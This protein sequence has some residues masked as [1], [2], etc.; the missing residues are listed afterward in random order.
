VTAA[1]PDTA[2]EL[3]SID[4]SVSRFTVR[5]FASG[6]LSAMGHSP[7]IAIRDFSGEARFNRDRPEASSLR[8]EIHASSLEVTDDIKSSD[9]REIESTMH[10]TV[11]ET[12]RYPGIVFETSGV[13]AELVAPGRYRMA[14]NGAL[15]LHGVT[16]ALRLVA[17]VI[18]VGDSLRAFGEFAVGQSSFGIAPVSVA[19]GTL[20]LKDELKCDFDIVAR[21]Q[22]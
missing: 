18:L 6:M 22:D 14:L 10:Q 19:G 12:A 1:N 17:Q 3:Y 13:S 9:R 4:K 20:K 8:L 16:R 7:T 5:A 2:V 15:T 21:K 11:L